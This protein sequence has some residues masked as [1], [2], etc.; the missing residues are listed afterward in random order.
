MVNSI[1]TTTDHNSG[2]QMLTQL[3]QSLVPKREHIYPYS[4]KNYPQTP[5][6]HGITKPQFWLLVTQK[7]NTQEKVL[8][9]KECELY[10]EGSPPGEKVDS[11]P[12]ANVEVSAWSRGF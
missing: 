10:S 6:I 2:Y 5:L 8:V 9:G 4:K 1:V 3:V 7:A 12:L 11:C